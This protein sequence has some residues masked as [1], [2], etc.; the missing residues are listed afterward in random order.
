MRWTRQRI[1]AVSGA[2]FAAHLL[3]IF[4]FHTR[5]PILA[6]IAHAEAPRPAAARP[7]SGGAQVTL[8]LTDPLVFASAHPHGF[9][10]PAWLTRPEAIHTL[11]NPASP[12]RFLAYTRTPMALDPGAEFVRPAARLP[13]LKFSIPP[14][15]RRS[16][17]EIYGPIAGRAPSKLPEL[18]IQR[19]GDVLSNTVVQVG[20]EAEGFPL[21]ARVL[22]G[23]GSRAADLEALGI[24]DSMRFVALPFRAV[25][26]RDTM[27]WGQLVFQWFTDAPAGTNAVAAA[28]AG[29]K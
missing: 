9:S 6:R 11:T 18:P 16:L 26:E 12:P 28:A 4:A 21:S 15:A 23:S 5:E 27:E 24:A 29:K 7:G 13:F 1:W 22:A 10:A 3:A 8:D 25:G 19:A 2:L 20:I 14:P 17:L